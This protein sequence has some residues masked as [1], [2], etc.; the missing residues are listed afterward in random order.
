[1]TVWVLVL[2]F[3]FA[4]TQATITVGDIASQQECKRLGD[5]MHQTYRGDIACFQ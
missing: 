1:M 5:V 4:Q 2:W 3:G